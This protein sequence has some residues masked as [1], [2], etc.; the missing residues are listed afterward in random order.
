MTVM[1]MRVSWL[2]E[3]NA[4]DEKR[5]MDLSDPDT[6]FFPLKTRKGNKSSRG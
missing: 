6:Y 4:D 1:R 2:R 5:W 3:G